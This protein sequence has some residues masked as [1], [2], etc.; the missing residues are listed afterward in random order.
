MVLDELKLIELDF[1]G[2]GF[3]SMWSQVG[4]K[5]L[6]LVATGDIGY[7]GAKCFLEADGWGRNNAVSIAG[8]ELNYEEAAKL[9]QEKIGRPMPTTFGFMGSLIKTMSHEMGS[10]FRWFEDVGF[11]ADIPALRKEAPQMKTFGQWLVE[12]S[13]FKDEAVR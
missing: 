12:S 7:W 10:M 2:K 1:L 9:F 8:D 5:R 11:A 6:Q 3:A 13:Q 4:N